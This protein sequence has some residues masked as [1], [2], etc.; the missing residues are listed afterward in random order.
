M[1][2]NAVAFL[3]LHKHREGVT[4][5][6]LVNSLDE[7]RLDLNLSRKDVGFVGD[8]I[9]VINY[10]IDLLGPGIVRREKTNNEIRIKPETILPNVIELNYYSN[11]LVT[12]YALD[13]IIAI[14]ICYLTKSNNEVKFSELLEEVLELCKLLQYEFILCKPCQQLEHVVTSCID[15]LT[16]RHKI[17]LENNEN[18]QVLKSRRIAKQFDDDDDLVEA[19]EKPYILNTQTESLEYLKFLRGLVQPLIETYA[20]TAFV[21]EKLVGRS[22]IENE[23]VEDVIKELQLQLGQNTINYGK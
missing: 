14:A 19:A 6:R 9:D 7:L 18:E 16:V 23:L 2:T 11:T 15:D 8:S 5:E 3:L 17:F 13:S 20:I 1:S 22:L 10:A 12:H 4:I 21:L